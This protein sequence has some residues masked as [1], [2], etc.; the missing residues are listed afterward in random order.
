VEEERSVLKTI[1]QRKHRWMRHMLR[2]EVLLRE[3][4]EGRMKGNAF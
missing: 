1:W 2:D 4:T 3:I